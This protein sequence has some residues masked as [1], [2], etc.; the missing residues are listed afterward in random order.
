[1]SHVSQSTVAEAFNSSLD[2]T[3]Q[4]LSGFIVWP[5]KEQ[6]RISLPVCFRATLDNCTS[7]V[8]RLE[9]CSEKKTEYT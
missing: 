7:V 5:G 9:I 6:I 2:V 4:R 8:E 1:M 3:Y